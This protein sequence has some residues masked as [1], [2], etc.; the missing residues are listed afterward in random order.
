MDVK[1]VKTGEVGM[2]VGI[3]AED[4]VLVEFPD[5]TREW[6]CE[7]DFNGMEHKNEDKDMSDISVTCEEFR[8]IKAECDTLK[9]QCYS[10]AEELGL[11]W[12]FEECKKRGCEHTYKCRHKCNTIGCIHSPLW[13]D[14]I[15]FKDKFRKKE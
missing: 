6:Y 3:D 5:G 1:I 11:I 15:N 13:Y 8:R 7:S 4:S 12:T 2:V 9:E 10:K 14:G